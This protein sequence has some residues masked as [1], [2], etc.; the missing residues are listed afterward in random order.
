MAKAMYSIKVYLFREQF[1][2]MKREEK[3]LFDISQFVVL[4]YIKAWFLSPS[5]VRAP[6][7]D[8]NF[9]KS[10]DLYKNVY[11]DISKVATKKILGHLWY[12][13]EELVTLALYEQKC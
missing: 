1:K 4:I 9:L 6:L 7:Q 8:L 5:P 13:G 12:I 3:A 2:L 11:P 10:L